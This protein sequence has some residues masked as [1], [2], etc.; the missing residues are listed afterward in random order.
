[1]NTPSSIKGGGTA[2]NHKEDYFYAQAKQRYAR[3]PD[4]HKS[5]DPQGKKF[6]EAQRHGKSVKC[7]PAKK[8]PSNGKYEKEIDSPNG[9]KR[10]TPG[11]E[12]QWAQNLG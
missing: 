8:T 9:L 7:F 6:P 10:G 11:Y 3:H 5:T 4:D 2:N 1:L 12:N